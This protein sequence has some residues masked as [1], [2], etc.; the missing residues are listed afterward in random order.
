M[1]GRVSEPPARVATGRLVP[2]LRRAAVLL[3]VFAAAGVVAGLVWEWIW[4]PPSGVVIEH[5]YLLDGDGLRA[6][7]SGTALY[8]LVGAVA[9]LLVGVGIAV[10]TE[11]AELVTLAA[12]AVGSALAG[13]LMLLVGTSVDPPDPGPVAETSE[14]LTELPDE[15]EV[16]GWSPFVAFPSGALVGLTVVFV[17]LAGRADGAVGP[18]THRR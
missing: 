11:G 9:G 1:P 15:L 8:V 14:D 16:S 7:F 3:V 18:R 6:T 2:T 4:T 12:V 17:G 13:W 5:E 10:L